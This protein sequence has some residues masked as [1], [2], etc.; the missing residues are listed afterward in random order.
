MEAVRLLG[1]FVR[2]VASDSKCHE[3]LLCGPGG[4]STEFAAEAVAS[5]LAPA[6]LET[7]EIMANPAAMKA[8]RAAE[9]GKLKFRDWAEVEAEL[10]AERG[11][12]SFSK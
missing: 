6:K 4:F 8:I 10:E 5:M 2:F 3:S 7:L 11:K 1:E 9:S 12:K